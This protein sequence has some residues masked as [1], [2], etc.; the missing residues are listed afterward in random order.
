MGLDYNVRT[1][2]WITMCGHGTGLQCEDMG[3]DYN[4]R[5]WDWITM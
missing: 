5:T 4:V 1:W 3:L 2:D